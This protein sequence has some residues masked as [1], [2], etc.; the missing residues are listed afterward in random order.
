MNDLFRY[1]G[2]PGE[3][4]YTEGLVY[5]LELQGRGLKFPIMITAPSEREYQ[6]WNHFLSEWERI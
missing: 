3:H 4:G 6:S 1:K 5:M 2:Q